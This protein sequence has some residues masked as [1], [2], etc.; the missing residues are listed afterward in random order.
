[1]N[2]LANIK[3]TMTSREIAELTGKRHSDV[4]EAIRQM[5]PAWVKVNGRSFPLVEY[6]DS[7]GE[8]RPM[9]QLSKTE[10][11]Y[12]ATKFNDEA[13]AKLILRWEMLESE[14]HL[15]FSNPATVVMLAQNWAEEQQKRLMAERRVKT[16]EQ[17]TVLMDK[18]LDT[19]TKIDIGQ[20]AKILELPFGRNTLFIKL[21][22]KGI[23]FK[24]RN[25]PKQEYIERGYFQLKERIIERENNPSFVV[26][27]VIVT[28]KGLEFLG[29]LFLAVP[30]NKQMAT[31]I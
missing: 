8:K 1:M 12:V 3:Q 6:T 27:K 13:R 11:L 5:E 20:A 31:I 21:R 26:I 23:F 10:C 16:L 7:K 4:L 18:V 29:K 28:Q 9:Y 24:N 2:T 25:E 17:K 19:D 14:K 22:E 15:D 30:A